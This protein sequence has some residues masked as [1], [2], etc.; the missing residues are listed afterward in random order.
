MNEFTFVMFG[1]WW[2]F[3][4]LFSFNDRRRFT[5]FTSTVNVFSINS[6][7][8]FM[9]RTKTSYGCRSESCKKKCII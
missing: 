3:L 6:E 4:K 1:F 2:F 7:L 8:I 9:S 5:W